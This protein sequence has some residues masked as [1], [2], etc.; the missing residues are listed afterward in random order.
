MQR[1]LE[2]AGGGLPVGDPQHRLAPV[3]ARRHVDGAGGQGAV[4]EGAVVGVAD[5]LGELTHQVEAELGGQP[6]AVRVEVGVQTQIRD[7]VAEQDGGAADV[8]ADLYGLHDAAVVDALQDL[9]LAAGRPVHR[10]AL[11]GRGGFAGQVDPYPAAFLDQAV[12]TFRQTVLPAGARIQGTRLQAPVVAVA[13][14]RRGV[15][16]TDPLDQRF[17]ELAGLW[18]DAPALPLGRQAQQAV[19]DP[20][21][22]AATAITPEDRGLLELVELAHQIRVVQEDGRLDEGNPARIRPHAAS[23][24]L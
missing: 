23:G 7:A 5:R 3:L 14:V 18:G 9:V 20:R 24:S 12:V 13:Q 22:P 19:P 4:V 17:E 15:A 1:G 8:F 11:L 16:D 6:A 2:I 10:V 21:Q